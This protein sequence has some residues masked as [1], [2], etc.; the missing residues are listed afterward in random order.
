MDGPATSTILAGSCRIRTISRVHRSQSRTRRRCCLRA[1]AFGLCLIFGATLVCSVREAGMESGRPSLASK[2]RKLNAT[3][4]SRAAGAGAL[5]TATRKHASLNRDSRTAKAAK[6]SNRVATEST[7]LGSSPGDQARQTSS[8]PAEAAASVVRR[9][10][11]T[12]KPF[13]S[14]QP[15]LCNQTLAVIDQ[16]GFSELSPVQVL[17]FCEP[18]VSCFCRRYTVRSGAPAC[19]SLVTHGCAGSHDP[20]LADKQGRRRASPDRLWQDHRL[21]RAHLRDPSPC[22]RRRRASGRRNRM[23]VALGRRPRH[24]PNPGAGRADRGHQQGV[25]SPLRARS[26]R[27]DRGFG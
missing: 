23:A 24:R 21:P 14:I 20:A 15:P 3:D 27:A 1:Y 7:L 10:K 17:S 5:A 22:G 13:T 8:S 18:T 19:T 12:G 11:L 25:F 26:A 16:L 6:R 4:G 9:P 2:A